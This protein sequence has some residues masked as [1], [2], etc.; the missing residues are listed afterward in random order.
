M[1]FGN[2]QLRLHLIQLLCVAAIG[3]CAPGLSS[4]QVHNLIETS[5]VETVGSQNRMGTSVALTVSA[6]APT[7]VETASP[8]PTPMETA[9][10]MLP[11]PT[12]TPFSAP[13]TG[14]GGRPA[15][16]CDITQ[17]PFDETAYKP[18]DPF[19]IKWTITNTG[20][21][22]WAAG[23]DFK[24]SSGTQLT[25]VGFVEL[26]EMKPYDK[27][28]VSLDANAPLTKGRYVMTWI[29]QDWLCSTSVVIISGRPGIDP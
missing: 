2:H 3:A 19:D 25:A 29:V 5:V 15:Y 24:F 21:K 10:E 7:A 8:T 13:I 27:F 12:A 17:R 14:G 6:L 16:A 22:T 18:G 1:Q 28:S 4:D 9:T 20:T 26:P 11:G 23:T